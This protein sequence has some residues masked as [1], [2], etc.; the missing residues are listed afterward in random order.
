MNTQIALD[1]YAQALRQG[2]KEYRELLMA[3]KP[4]HPA[5]LDEILPE[6]STES[7]MN[8]GLVDIPAERIVGTKTA[9]RITAFTAS[10]RPLLDQKTEFGSKWVNLCKAHLGEA[11][12]SDPIECFEYLG[13][14]YVQ[15]G[16]KRVSVLRHFGAPRITGTVRRILPQQSEEPR[17]KAY[18]EFVEFYKASRLYI[19]QFRRPGDY[20]KLLSY[21]GKKS[22]E[23]WTEE[24]RRTFNSYY[25][26]FREA[27]EALNTRDDVLPEEALL[28][29][30][31]LYP[32]QDLGR[33]TGAQLRK[34]L[35]ALRD[36]V[37][38]SA[39]KEEAV[40]VQTKAE[41]ESKGS[42]VSRIVS[43]LDQLDVAFVHQLEASKSAWVMGHEEGREHIEAVFGDRIKVRTYFGA[44][45]PEQAEA[46]IE[47][48]VA[49]GAQVVFT[50]AP[51][52]SRATLKAAV[53]YPKVR[54]LNCSVD[55]PY[56]SIR[57]YY[58]RIYESKFI[59]GAI[60]GAMA[61]NNRIGYIASYPIFGVTA[62][63]NAFALGAQM[64]NPRAQIELRWSCVEGTPQADFFADGI[65]VISNR[66]APTQSKMYL[67]FCNYGTYLMDDRGDLVPLGTPTWVWGKFYEFVIRSILSGGWKREKGVSTALNYWLGMDSGVIGVNLSDKLPEGVRQ[68]AKLLEK[69]LTD[70]VLDPFLR[71]IIAQDGTMKNDGTRRFTP[72][73]LLRMDWLCENVIGQIPAFEEILPIS[74]NM[75][76]ELGLYRDNIPAEKEAKSREDL[77]HLR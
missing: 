47:Q 69:G 74:Q 20:A 49:D 26:Y 57:T 41:D 4:P 67:D 27:F 58:G 22:G 32:F 54:F 55:Q 64:T 63:I 48:A 21:M 11:G 61:Q 71:K 28:L 15:E 30:L 45:S 52:L 7:V 77:D 6:I 43:V 9:G 66:N 31:K 56:S 40:K 62:S 59:T 24:E 13:N 70:S 19:L 39:R 46:L 29:W 18:Y 76:R 75:V 44:N 50:T 16:N 8:L 65:R 3:G 12:I 38:A 35:I 5:V 42:I 53:K 33:L 60:A 68:M 34:S 72:G 10:F 37:I 25:H 1:E 51:P 36:D 73:E 14:F 2:Q 23:V 17:I